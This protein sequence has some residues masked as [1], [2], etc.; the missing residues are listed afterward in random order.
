MCNVYKR[1]VYGG[2]M[3]TSDEKYERMQGL[4]EQ[5][6]EL[7]EA[8]DKKVGVLWAER[9]EKAEKAEKEAEKEAQKEARAKR[10][11][12]QRR[13]DVAAIAAAEA[14]RK[15]RKRQE[16]HDKEMLTY[17]LLPGGR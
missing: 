6:R 17:G 2:V 4:L 9:R 14:A 15:N 8:T 12:A 16:E 7:A 5:L 1:G 11:E 10:D 3:S 13:Q